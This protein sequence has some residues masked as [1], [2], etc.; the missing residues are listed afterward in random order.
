MTLSP[1]LPGQQPYANRWPALIVPLL[2]CLIG[3]R[4]VAQEHRSEK[5]RTIQ[6]RTQQLT[7]ELVR[8]VLNDQ[9]RR[10]DEN[11]LSHVPL[12]KEIAAARN[13]L[14]R[15]AA[16][17][18]QQVVD[19]LSNVGPADTRPPAVHRAVRELSRSAVVQI[20]VERQRIR[21]R[22]RVSGSLTLIQQIIDRQVSSR[23]RVR[24]VAEEQIAASTKA[25]AAIHRQQDVT[26]L[27]P[28]L[29]RSLEESVAHEGVAGASA[30]DALEIFRRRELFKTS[31][32][33]VGQ[34]KERRYTEALAEQQHI[35]DSLF[36]MVRDL[37]RA[38]GISSL[39]QSAAIRLIEKLTETQRRLK[40][41][42]TV[43]DLSQP[44]T[45]DQLSTE[46]LSL[47]R[48]VSGM[49]DRLLREIEHRQQA[50]AAVAAAKRAEASL[51]DGLDSAAVE[52]QAEVIA[53]LK[54]I[55]EGLQD[56]VESDARD[57]GREAEQL[58]GLSESVTRALDLQNQATRLASSNPT[59]AADLE[60]RVA[61]ELSGA[62]GGELS[63]S[64]SAQFEAT[65]QAVNQAQQAMR[66]ADA[67]ERQRA[68]AAAAEAL[69]ELAEE[70]S[71]AQTQDA[72]SADSSSEPQS[73]QSSESTDVAS[74]SQ[75]QQTSTAGET[76]Q[77][78]R[79]QEDPGGAQDENT[80]FDSRMGDSG[81]DAN[82]VDRRYR[83]APWFAKLPPEI[84]RAIQARTRASTPRGYEERLRRYFGNAD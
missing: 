23:E 61:D 62:E 78:Q 6:A 41:V 47:R 25:L 48:E 53:R 1:S 77:R 11:G 13:N 72:I 17:E 14:D 37:Q 31:E 16:D 34:L 58:S 44:Q 82:V 43:A 49:R 19:L 32:K 50:D 42:T 73:N 39:N 26:S 9:L 27:L 28:Q 75:S 12:Y 66:D 67:A 15:V 40:A 63:D 45:R 10:L 60:D 8:G 52:N 5:A 81:D 33:V 20:S 57:Q 70:V 68:A 3:G 21:E 7:V 51:F 24:E 80:T 59:A 35:L 38:Q 18:M 74:S 22:L 56:E 84:R 30:A 76:D 36:A 2:A 55:A 65:Q 64:I 4:I 46:Q 83:D 79:P 54:R 29:E 71:S 69:A